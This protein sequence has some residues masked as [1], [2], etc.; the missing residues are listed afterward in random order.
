MVINLTVRA[1]PIKEQILTDLSPEIYRVL[2]R[3]FVQAGLDG[4]YDVLIIRAPDIKP[5]G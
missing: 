4:E 5:G 1:S 2:T 3:L